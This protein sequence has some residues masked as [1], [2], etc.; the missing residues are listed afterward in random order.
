M[1]AGKGDESDSGLFEAVGRLTSQWEHFEAYFGLLF[2]VL[3]ESRGHTDG[4]MRAYG[5]V[6]SFKGRSAMVT[7]AALA[8]FTRYP[9]KTLE[10]RLSAL[11]GRAGDPS[12]KRNEVAYG[13][14]QV[15]FPDTKERSG[16]ALVPS[17]NATNKRVI[18]V[19]AEGR[20]LA[21][22]KATG[23]YAYVSS[24]IYNFIEEIDGLTKDTMHLYREVFG[25]MKTMRTIQERSIL[26]VKS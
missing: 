2:G 20:G 22:F 16:F 1:I 10:D 3:V 7:A 21:P 19:A 9:D 24:D 12:G 4:A 26:P 17:F 5:T 6:V 8:F 11:T 25:L 14:V 13:I 23:K 18:E 15:Y